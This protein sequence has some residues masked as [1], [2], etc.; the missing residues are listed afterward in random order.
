M[1]RPMHR[2]RTLRRVAVR[3][4]GG[5]TTIHY[6]QRKPSKARCAQTGEPLHGIPRGTPS[7]MKALAKSKKRPSRPF[8]GFLS[9]RAMRMLLRYEAREEQ[10]SQE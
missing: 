8:G 10:P 9:S 4:P 2:S 3:L 5:E 1:V 6:K 7:Q